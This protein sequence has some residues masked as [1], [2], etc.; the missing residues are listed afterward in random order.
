MRRKY[1]EP[2]QRRSSSEDGSANRGRHREQTQKPS[3]HH[4]IPS[5]RVAVR[6]PSWRTQDPSCAL[7]W[8]SVPPHITRKPTYLL[9]GRLHY[10]LRLPPKCPFQG[11]A[12]AHPLVHFAS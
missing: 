9:V 10:S 12:S 2:L 3:L 8:V 11:E 4:S 5:T 1:L 6:S 7:Q